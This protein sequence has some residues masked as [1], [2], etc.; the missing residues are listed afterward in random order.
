VWHPRI[1]GDN[2]YTIIDSAHDDYQ[3]AGYIR[4]MMVNPLEQRLPSLAVM[5]HAHCNR[6]DIP[7]LRDDWVSTKA[8]AEELISPHLGDLWGRGSDGDARRFALQKEGMDVPPTADGR[9]GL[10]VNGVAADGF[11]QSAK[12]LQDGRLTDL[13]SQDW[14]HCLS[15]LYSHID[16]SARDL[17]WGEQPARHEHVVLVRDKL[18]YSG[19][20]GHGITAAAADRF[21]RQNKTA[22]ALCCAR[23]ARRGVK[24]LMA[25]NSSMLHTL[26]YLELISRYIVLNAGKKATLTQRMQS[27]SYIIGS[28]RRARCFVASDHA[29][30]LN[31]KDNFMPRQTYEHVVLSCFS[32]AIK[33]LARTLTRYKTTRA[34]LDK[35]GSNCCEIGFSELGGFGR[36]AAG[37]RDYTANGALEGVS[38]INTLLSYAYEGEVSMPRE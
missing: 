18:P 23:G 28:L 16:N 37:K 11:T 12:L 33:L 8:M 1:T 15:K 13:H 9:F 7:W 36:I 38:D 21:D 35:S 17:H 19:A 34:A 6:F 20:D 10:V 24:K 27:A 31:L 2:A 25:D 26:K 3:L 4:L 5:V 22:P 29:S 30:G 14:R 32:S